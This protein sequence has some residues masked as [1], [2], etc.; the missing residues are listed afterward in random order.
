MP[1]G[2]YFRPPKR[3]SSADAAE[4][5][6][7]PLGRHDRLRRLP[8]RQQD[9][10]GILSISHCWTGFRVMVR[11]TGRM[12]YRQLFGTRSS[13]GLLTGPNPTDR[14]KRRSE[15]PLDLRWS[16]IPLAI[17]LTTANIYDS[18]QALPLLDPSST[19]KACVLGRAVARI[20]CW[21][22]GLTMPNA[23]SVPYAGR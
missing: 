16:G 1:R 8:D 5:T 6:G 19:L 21:G 14:A 2:H 10:I 13:W 17:K 18:T 22:T 20:V 3:Y 7:L 9:G 11:S 23:L 12:L 4:R 15:A